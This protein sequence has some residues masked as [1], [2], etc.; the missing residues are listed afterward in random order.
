MNLELDDDLEWNGIDEAEGG[1]LDL[2]SILESGLLLSEDSDSSSCRSSSPESLS[3]E[4]GLLFDT[5]VPLPSNTDML[6]FKL[7]Q[8]GAESRSEK[9]KR[10]RNYLVED[11]AFNQLVFSSID[12]PAPKKKKRKKRKKRTP[13]NQGEN[14]RSKIALSRPRSK[15]R[16][17][18]SE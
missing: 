7:T 9:K 8:T 6:A 14:K 3:F 10:A 4:D 16:F 13:L 5:P 18:E 2:E 1:N 12:I 15:G 11:D 17:K